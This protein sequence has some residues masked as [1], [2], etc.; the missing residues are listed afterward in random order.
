VIGET[1]L[2]EGADAGRGATMPYDAGAAPAEAVAVPAMPVDIALATALATRLAVARLAGEP[3]DRY[4]RHGEQRGNVLFLSLR[5]DFWVFAEAWDRF[6]YQVERSPQ[7][8]ACGGEEGG[9]GR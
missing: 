6:V 7:C 8:P 3:M 5:P 4:L 1:G 2:D 9:D